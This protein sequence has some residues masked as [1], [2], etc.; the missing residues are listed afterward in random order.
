MLKLNYD[1]L[2]GIIKYL[3][4]QSVLNLS[5]CNKYLNYITRKR[6]RY[7]INCDVD[8]IYDDIKVYKDVYIEI[9]FYDFKIKTDII[10]KRIDSM[11]VITY[12]NFNLNRLINKCDD[13]YYKCVILNN[14]YYRNYLTIIL[15]SKETYI[16][17]G[18][19]DT[20]T[21]TDYNSNFLYI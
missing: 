19:K 9:G 4:L 2:I 6:K 10:K 16:N 8:K 20:W 14:N 5:K 13:T 3:N 1:C 11:R 21:M 7:L 18:V 12:N 15:I 17:K